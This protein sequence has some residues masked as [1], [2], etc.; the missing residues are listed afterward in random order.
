MDKMRVLQTIKIFSP[1]SD[2]E[3]RAVSGLDFRLFRFSCGKTIIRKGE[4][5]TD[6]FFLLK[7]TVTVLGDD[8]IPKAV[9][10]AGD[11]FGEIAF[12]NA[13]SPRTANVV[14][15]NDVIVMR[16]ERPMFQKLEAPLKEKLKDW[17]IG[18]LVENLLSNQV[19]NNPSLSIH[20]TE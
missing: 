20:L 16:L 14:A 5:K 6:L 7:G 1:L 9:L 8:A 17:L 13:A 10:K 2:R 11:L 12:L 3:K 18:I 19:E 4:R 15:N